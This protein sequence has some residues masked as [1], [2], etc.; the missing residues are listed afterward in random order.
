MV[1]AGSGA[2]SR[3]HIK[4]E[5]VSPTNALTGNNSSAVVG[6][7]PHI[8]ASDGGFA[9]L[10]GGQA[11]HP[12]VIS[13]TLG[14]VGHGKGELTTLDFA[15]DGFISVAVPSSQLGHLV[16]S[17]GASVAHSGKTRAEGGQVFLNAA[18]ASN[19][20]RDAV[21]V[22]GAVRAN[23]VGAYN[24]RIVIGGGAV[25]ASVSRAGPRQTATTAHERPRGL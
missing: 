9:A 11:S 3:L 24:G 18:T 14:K 13:A 2:A 17:S 10:L 5:H 21:N 19:I 20:L 6:N 22:P 7:V 8:N 23:S 25:A 15:G 1:N 12:G 16:D 4:N